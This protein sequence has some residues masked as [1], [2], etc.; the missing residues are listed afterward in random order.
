M[1]A[2]LGSGLAVSTTGCMSRLGGS[3]EE[4]QYLAVNPRLQGESPPSLYSFLS[5]ESIEPGETSEYVTILGDGEARAQPGVLQPAFLS[6][7]VWKNLLSQV[8]SGPSIFSL[9]LPDG[10]GRD[11]SDEVTESSTDIITQND[12]GFILKGSYD[13]SEL[14]GAVLSDDFEALEGTYND[15]FTGYQGRESE[16]AMTDE[17]IVAAGSTNGNVGERSPATQSLISVCTESAEEEIT[18]FSEMSST[19]ESITRG[20][21]VAGVI[22]CDREGIA[23]IESEVDRVQGGW[24]TDSVAESSFNSIINIGN[25]IGDIKSVGSAVQE[26]EEDKIGMSVAMTFGENTSPT[27]SD[28]DR[29]LPNGSDTGDFELSVMENSNQ[30]LI[31]AVST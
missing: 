6:P 4:N 20:T 12:F 21:T 27:K 18:G 23:P 1:K 30:L 31:E 15:D 25:E 24:G 26:L 8:N 3:S 29:V 7:I 11:Y 14:R 2:I 9:T 5:L 22:K 19:I 17:L 13:T 10:L 28:I 16:I